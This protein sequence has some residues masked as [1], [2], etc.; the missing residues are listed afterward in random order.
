MRPD[1]DTLR[2]LD[3]LAAEVRRFLAVIAA[4]ERLVERLS[5]KCDCPAQENAARQ[6]KVFSTQDMTN[7]ERAAA[8]RVADEDRGLLQRLGDTPVAHATPREGSE[9]AGGTLTD[10]DR[11][12]LHMWLCEC[13]RLCS[14]ATDGGDPEAAE[15][16]SGRAVRAAAML[17]RQGGGA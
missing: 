3:L 6:D 12:D 14:S 4:G 5:Q 11:E 2:D 8:G 16:W 10:E 13:L 7:T 9:Q 1:P 17:E 15:R